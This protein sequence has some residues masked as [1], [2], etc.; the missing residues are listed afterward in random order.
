[1][2]IAIVTALHRPAQLTFRR[3]RRLSR[4]FA[5]VPTFKA[6][7]P[8]DHAQAHTTVPA[9]PHGTRADNTT[10]CIP[11]ACPHA[12]EFGA[13]SVT[14]TQLLLLCGRQRQLDVPAAERTPMTLLV[15]RPN[16]TVPQLGGVEAPE[17]HTRVGEEQ[18]PSPPSGHHS[19]T[20]VWMAVT[21]G[22]V[23]TAGD[24]GLLLVD[25]SS[26][27]AV[28]SSCGAATSSGASAS[29]WFSRSLGVGWP[30]WKSPQ[31]ASHRCTLHAVQ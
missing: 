22:G 30:T 29:C 18:F 8:S 2:T 26:L 27:Q 3:W 15:F 20:C 12:S 5:P 13:W 25:A 21:P 31:Q 4:H 6:A 7:V 16:R 19:C 14:S 23:A 24:D 28:T 17:L 10:A 9:L 1:M 11:H